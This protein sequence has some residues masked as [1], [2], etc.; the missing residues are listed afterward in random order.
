MASISRARLAGAVSAAGGLGFIGSAMMSPDEVRREVEELRR[1][2]D[3]PFGLNFFVHAEPRR[4]EAREARMRERLEEYRQELGAGE[5][6]ELGAPPPFD[7]AML[8]LV[9]ELAPPVVSF[10]FGVPDASSREALR[11]AKIRIF[12]SATSVV[13]ARALEAWGVD[14]VI[15]QGFEAG[16]HR[17]TFASRFS[18]GELGLFALVP[19]IV[20]AVSVPVIAA[21]GI[22]DGRGIAA[23]RMLGA[24]AVQM[25][26]AFLG[27]PEADID[28]SYRNVL[29]ST[30]AA[31]TRVTKLFSGRPARTIVTRFLEEMAES[32]SDTP[33]YPLQR[34]WTQWLSKAA[35]AR[36][37]LEFSAFWAGQ[38]APLV[39]A[40]PASELVLR[41]EREAAAALAGA[42]TTPS[43]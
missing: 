19:Q 35:L 28:P 30:R 40:M 11:A 23:A 37:D 18:D 32:E 38:A 12:A 14:A 33:E 8:E 17:A 13:E 36:N 10:H 1:L 42:G 31:R 16:G 34:A 3:K 9:F 7:H 43:T 39:R 4:Y 41:L 20:D 22:A 15:A 6:P 2:T 29:G 27:C 25:G 5:F 24:A 26:T 21:G